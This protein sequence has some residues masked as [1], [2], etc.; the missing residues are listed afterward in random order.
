MKHIINKVSKANGSWEWKPEVTKDIPEVK[1][2]SSSPKKRRKKK[3]KKRKPKISRLDNKKFYS[4][5]AWINLRARVLEKYDCS[6]MMCG[7]SPKLHGVVLH[8]DHIKPRR[9]YPELALDFNNLQLLCA[10]CNRGKGNKYETD[11]RCTEEEAEEYL[12]NL[13]V[14]NILSQ[15]L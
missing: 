4:S 15:F 12:D 2:K 9:K 1:F 5:L 14:H 7:R 3:E 13:V 11:Y 10:D 6:C 8:V